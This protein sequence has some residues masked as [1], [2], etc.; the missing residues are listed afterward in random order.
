MS[1]MNANTLQ[2]VPA[3]GRLVALLCLV[4]VSACD[5][6]EGSQRPGGAP[7]VMVEVDTVR[8]ESITDV[9]E[10][11]GQLEAE[12]SVMIKPETE[13]T[14]TSIEFAEGSRVSSGA[15][16]FRVTRSETQGP[17]T[18]SSQVWVPMEQVT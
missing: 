11:V 2:Q 15:L 10:L 6:T 3:T 9:V 8:R 1:G 18:P 17:Q 12:E 13:G 5:G 4:V 7:P 16:L 14:I